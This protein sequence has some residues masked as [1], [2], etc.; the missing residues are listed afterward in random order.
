[1]VVVKRAALHDYIYVYVDG[2]GCRV[3]FDGK[4]PTVAKEAVGKGGFTVECGGKSIRV[5][6]M[7]AEPSDGVMCYRCKA[8]FDLVVASQGRYDPVPTGKECMCIRCPN[9]PKR[10]TAQAAHA[11]RLAAPTME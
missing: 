5:D 3:A 2:G 7:L 11:A 4:L 10:A 1:M 6:A 9:P 8:K